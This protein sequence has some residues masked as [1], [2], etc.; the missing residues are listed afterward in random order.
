VVSLIHK[1][2]G[3]IPTADA[4]HGQLVG[5][6]LAHKKA[7]TC[8]SVSHTEEK[9]F[10]SFKLRESEQEK[11]ES[12]LPLEQ[13]AVSWRRGTRNQTALGVNCL[14]GEDHKVEKNKK[15]G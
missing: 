3:A 15:K 11:R 6:E 10:H 12:T 14:M 8:V 1:V 5:W 4:F 7:V 13:K 2:E 9:V